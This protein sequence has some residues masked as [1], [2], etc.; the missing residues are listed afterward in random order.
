MQCLSSSKRHPLDQKGT[1]EED[2]YIRDFLSM[3][4]TIKVYGF[5]SIIKVILGMEKD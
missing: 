3:Q 2:E 1:G 4:V 5:S